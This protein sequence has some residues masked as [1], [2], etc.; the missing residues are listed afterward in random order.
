MAQSLSENSKALRSE[1]RS[2]TEILVP[3]KYFMGLSK[4][5]SIKRATERKRDRTK[6]RHV[7]RVSDKLKIV[8][9][10]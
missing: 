9:K 7:K 10:E 1:K 3:S 8:S 2:R 4:W 5:V 6:E